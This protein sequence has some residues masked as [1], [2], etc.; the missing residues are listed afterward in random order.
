MPPP[1][2]PGRGVF[3]SIF[4]KKA[5]GSTSH[6]ETEYMEP[7]VIEEMFEDGSANLS[8]RSIIFHIYYY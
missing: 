7:D 1:K 6:S 2:K 3:K 8:E 4:K 5:A